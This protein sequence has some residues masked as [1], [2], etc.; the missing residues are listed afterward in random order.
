MEVQVGLNQGRKNFAIFNMG[1]EPGGLQSKG[2]QKA[3]HNLTT[4]QQY[5]TEYS[6]E[7]T[8]PYQYFSLYTCTCTH[9]HTLKGL[10]YLGSSPQCN[11]DV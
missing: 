3:R 2:L 4:K 6:V 9:I 1:G 10:I 11:L 7:Q 8:H 5:I